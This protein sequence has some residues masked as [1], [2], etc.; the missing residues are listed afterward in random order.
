M[1]QKL[2]DIHMQKCWTFFLVIYTKLILS[3]SETYIS[4]ETIKILE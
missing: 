1:V 4:V 3:E 2:L